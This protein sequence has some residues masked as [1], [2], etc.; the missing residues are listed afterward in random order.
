MK[1]LVEL[2]EL[3]YVACIAEEHGISMK[4]FIKFLAEYPEYSIQNLVNCSECKYYDI[5]NRGFC[6]H[7]KSYEHLPIGYCEFGDDTK[8]LM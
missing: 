2:S 5:E 6:K 7:W 8:R 3:V 1:R 4:D